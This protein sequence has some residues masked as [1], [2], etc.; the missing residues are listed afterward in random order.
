MR[1][2]PI[3]QVRFSYSLRAS[4][5]AAGEMTPVKALPVKWCY[6]I[7]Y[8]PRIIIK[9]LRSINTMDNALDG[10]AIFL[11]PS[12]AFRFILAWGQNTLMVET[13]S[14]SCWE[15]PGGMRKFFERC[16]LSELRAFV[17]GQVAEGEYLPMF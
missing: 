5:A 9:A 17:T 14:W 2:T 3:C 13:V 10:L 8:I 1:R 16:G 12:G 6:K 15:V 11:I 7:S 4:F